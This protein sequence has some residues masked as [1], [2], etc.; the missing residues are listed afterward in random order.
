MTRL[1]VAAPHCSID[2]DQISAVGAE[3]TIGNAKIAQDQCLPFEPVAF[4][5]CAVTTSAAQGSCC[6]AG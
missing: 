2:R 6:G 3:I 4:A 5:P 1:M